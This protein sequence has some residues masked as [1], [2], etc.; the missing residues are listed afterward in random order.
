MET[1][2]GIALPGLTFNSYSPNY[3][4]KFTRPVSGQKKLT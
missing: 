1:D 4:K 3:L 2:G